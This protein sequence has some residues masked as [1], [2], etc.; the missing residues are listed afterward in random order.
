MAAC[1][2][3]RQSQ[4]KPSV[5]RTARSFTRAR[6]RAAPAATPPACCGSRRGPVEVARTILVA[7]IPPALKRP[8]GPG[9]DQN[10]LR[11]K[12]QMAAADPAPIHERAYVDE[13]LPTHNLSADDPIERAAVAQLIGALWHHA[14]AVHVLAR[15]STL[16]RSLR[17][18]DPVL[19]LLDRVTADTKLDEMQ[20]HGDLPYCSFSAKAWPQPGWNCAPQRRAGTFNIGA[21][22]DRI[23]TAPHARNHSKRAAPVA[24]RTR[25]LSSE[26]VRPIA[27]A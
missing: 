27:R 10:E 21:S 20:G 16:A 19:E 26:E 5:T 25:G 24:T 2:L 1:D 23:A 6:A 4:E 22:C 13:P 12:H 14:R 11:L 9:L 18:S 15:Q 7:E 8:P 3:R 17:F